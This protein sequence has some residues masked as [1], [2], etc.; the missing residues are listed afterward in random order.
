MP[1]A[2]AESIPIPVYAARAWLNQEAETASAVADAEGY[3]VPENE[4]EAK[5]QRY[6]LLW[7][8]S[9]EKSKVVSASDLR[10]GQTLIVPSSYSGAD[11][12]GWHGRIDE[13]T[14][15]VEDIAELA[16]RRQARFRVS[17]EMLA[18]WF[19]TAAQEA[20]D[21]TSE[22]NACLMDTPLFERREAVYALFRR[23]SSIEVF[24]D[25]PW[26][27][28]HLRLRA[29][30]LTQTNRLKLD[31]LE[32][33]EPNKQYLVV[34]LLDAKLNREIA[35]GNQTELVA[36]EDASDE[37]S[38]TLPPEPIVLEDHCEGVASE[39]RVS[40]TRLRLPKPLL[41]ALEF[42]AR[43]HDVGKC[44]DRFQL[45][46]HGGDELSRRGFDGLL[47][48]SLPGQ[49]SR[50]WKQARVLAT[51]P[52]GYRHEFLSV[53]MLAQSKEPLPDAPGSDLAELA[54]YIIGV[55]H[56]FGRPLPPVTQPTEGERVVETLH[57]TSFD[58]STSY[59]YERLGGG[60]PDLFW[61]LVRRC[62]WWTLS[63]LETLLRLAD[64]RRSRQEEQA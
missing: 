3:K 14:K 54:S 62:G 23:I 55:H 4:Q 44:D 16:F 9:A 59:P 42:T 45:W 53:W 13:N 31:V 37:G 24:P 50:S 5:K 36:S 48:K 33:L 7:L 34:T 51:Y 52:E 58:S 46:L 11:K 26:W 17:A 56:G 35:F 12:F 30:I 25:E 38:A 28:A 19:A 64:R 47:A 18:H 63:Y 20:P 29:N 57:E 40:A 43:W 49:S 6:A 10:P 8:G 41:H 61:K 22:A 2:S 32:T 60:W 15:P 27:L 1:P 39:L 21:L